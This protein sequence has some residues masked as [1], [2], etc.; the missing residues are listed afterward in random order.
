MTTYDF[1]TLNLDT[2]DPWSSTD[3]LPEFPL[4]PAWNT[5]RDCSLRE[6]TAELDYRYKFEAEKLLLMDKKRRMTVVVGKTD[7]TDATDATDE[8]FYTVEDVL[9][10]D[11]T[12][13]YLVKWEGYSVKDATW[14]P[15]E[16]LL[17]S[18]GVIDIVSAFNAGQ[19]APSKFQ[20]T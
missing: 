2:E 19:K 12:G 6:L 7:A 13:R 18:D 20:S 5:L 16:N 8:T 15:I 3:T 4:V 1:D 10:V 17:F 11:D 14:E 9:A